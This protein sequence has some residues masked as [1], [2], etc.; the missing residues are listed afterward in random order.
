MKKVKFKSKANHKDIF[1]VNTVKL[2][3]KVSAGEEILV[4]Q[5]DCLLIKLLG[6]IVY[7]QRL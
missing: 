4:M 2:K 6:D 1:E 7:N 5:V 3:D